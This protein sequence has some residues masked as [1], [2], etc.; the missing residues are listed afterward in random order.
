MNI[1]REGVKL[2]F[3]QDIFRMSD[4][5]LAASG[6]VDCVIVENGKLTRG[7]Y[8]DKLIEKQLWMNGCI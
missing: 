8:F 6:K 5:A 1:Q 7:E 3:F 4:D 2:V